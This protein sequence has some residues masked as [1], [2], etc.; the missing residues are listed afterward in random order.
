MRFMIEKSQAFAWLFLCRL[1]LVVCMVACNWGCT[2]HTAEVQAIAAGTTV[3]VL[4]DSI[5]YGT[6]AEH[7]T[8]DYPTLLAHKTGWQV[9]NAGISGDVSS[10]GLARL[11]GLLAQHRPRLV[12]IELGGND[13]LRQMAPTRIEDNLKSM[14]HLV[15]QADATAILIA[16][17]ELSLLG[18]LHDH[19]LY[20]RVAEET[21]ALLV[22]NAVSEVLSDGRLRADQVHPNAEGYRQLTDVLTKQFHDL[23]VLH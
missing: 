23:G 11:P 7:G 17:P 18:R 1:M 16:M 15:Q 5:S 14:V 8:Q 12:I 10:G 21:G 4:G 6:G 20:V 19:P 13:F 22:T 3:L 2:K 9:I